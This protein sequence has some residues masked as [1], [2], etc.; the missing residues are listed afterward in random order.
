MVHLPDTGVREPGTI[1]PHH[2][3]DPATSFNQRDRQAWKCSISLMQVHKFETITLGLKILMGII[4]TL[5]LGIR[6]GRSDEY[7]AGF[8]HAAHRVRSACR[9]RWAHD[10]G[11]PAAVP[12][13]SSDLTFIG[14]L[15]SDRA[16]LLR[17]PGKAHLVTVPSPRREGR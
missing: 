13:R 15:Y 7:H 5:T 4:G 1:G 14:R 2:P 8:G 3:G 11:H 12:R 16:G 9:R 6:R 17:F 10:G